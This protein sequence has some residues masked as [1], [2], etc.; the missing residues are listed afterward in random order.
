MTIKYLKLPATLQH[1]I[2][3]NKTS[4]VSISLAL[5]VDVN[6][7]F[8]RLYI[9]LPI[10]LYV[11]ELT[12]PIMSTDVFHF[13]TPSFDGRMV[14]TVSKDGYG[15]VV[16]LSISIIPTE[17]VRHL[18]WYAECNLLHGMSFQRLPLF[19]DQGVLLATALAFTRGNHSKDQSY[20]TRI[21]LNL[22]ICVIHYICLTYGHFKDALKEYEP[23]IHNGIITMSTS[24]SMDD[25][26]SSFFAH[27]RKLVDHVVSA[28]DFVAKVSK[29][30][31]YG[32]FLLRVHPRHWTAFANMPSFKPK[33]Y[34]Y[35][36][37]QIIFTLTFFGKVSLNIQ[38]LEEEFGKGKI[39]MKSVNDENNENKIQNYLTMVWKSI[40]TEV[41]RRKLCS[42]KDMQEFSVDHTSSC[43]SVFS[44]NINEGVAHCNSWIGGRNDIPP[45][46]IYKVL[47]DYTQKVVSLENKMKKQL[48]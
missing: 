31:F 16:L 36:R 17:N 34:E 40:K 27:L 22:H 28:S 5:Q 10:A 47:E 3:L 29:V 2:E 7:R 38:L 48:S 13:Q 9:G 26:F 33:L 8:L 32:V 18:G 41:G 44:T 24:L 12:L 4:G 35:Q 25:F 11:G 45:T 37:R 30:C 15:K 42:Y 23:I 6:G 14:C 43:F 1:I 46:V 21:I 20:Q 19:T 39:N